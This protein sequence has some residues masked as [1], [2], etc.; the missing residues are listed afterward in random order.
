MHYNFT[1]I[2]DA[3]AAHE[4]QACESINLTTTENRL[5]PLARKVLSTDIS[6]RY[7]IRSSAESD[8][9]F[10]GDTFLKE[11]ETEGNR[12]A[13]EIFKCDFADLKPLSG[14][15]CMTTMLL[16]LTDVNDTVLH[17][18]EPA[19]H[20]AVEPLC[21]KT[22]RKIANVPY[23]TETLTID[24]DVAEKL[25]EN[26]KPDLIYLDASRILFPHP[27]KELTSLFPETPVCYDGSHVLGLIAGGQFQDPLREGA[28]FLNGST[29]KTFPGPQKGIILANNNPLIENVESTLFP[30]LVSNHHLHHVTALTITLAE[31]KIFGEDYAKQVIKNSK[32]LAASLAE[33]GFN[34]QGEHLGYTESHQIWIDPNEEAAKIVDNLK[35]IGIMMNSVPIPSTGRRGLRLGTPEVTRR[36]MKEEQMEELAK[37][38]TSALTNK[39]TSLKEDVISLA[40]E[41]GG[42]EYCFKELQ[43]G[44]S[45]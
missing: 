15:H 37:I 13:R 7:S 38:I 34:V 17:I 21:Q 14:A 36:G 24:L 40:K 12:L 32:A 16:G 23:S 8:W 18:G 31:M 19:G 2:S 5:S 26:L 3:I 9:R 42:V 44:S 22:G 11:I 6:H 25:S 35:Q 4:K 45:W 1:A 43:E 29:H 33:E 41:F 28:L 39:T 27:L 10:P 20:F 30:M